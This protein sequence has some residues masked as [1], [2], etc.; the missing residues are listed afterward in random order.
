M[1]IDKF[2]F[3]NVQEFFCICNEVMEDLNIQKQFAVNLS[4]KQSDSFRNKLENASKVQTDDMYEFVV[5]FLMR[6]GFIRVL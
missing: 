4:D 3:N 2:Y 6:T 1:K 5:D